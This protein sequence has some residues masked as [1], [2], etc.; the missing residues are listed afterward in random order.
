M[1]HATI[2]MG[3]WMSPHFTPDMVRG[4]VPPP[5]ANY[6]VTNWNRLRDGL[7]AALNA[8]AQGIVLRLP[9]DAIDQTVVHLRM[10]GGAPGPADCSDFGPLLRE[11]ALRERG[12]PIAIRRHWAPLHALPDRTQAPPP[13]LLAFVVEGEGAAV[14]EWGDASMRLLRMPVA[15][16]PFPYQH[17]DEIPA[18]Q[19]EGR[20]PE[21][22]RTLLGEEFRIAY[23]PE[24]SLWPLGRVRVAEVLG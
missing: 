6:D 11:Q 7:D 15:E 5:R 12:Q 24:C 1:A 17:A 9:D 23:D 8:A 13:V 21:A 2:V 4:R 22:L 16:N 14:L 20:L 19:A 18:D 10:L 3:L